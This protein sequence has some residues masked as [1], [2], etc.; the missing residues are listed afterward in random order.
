MWTF[1]ASSQGSN[2]ESGADVSKWHQ[3][4]FPAAGI[5]YN[6]IWGMAPFLQSFS[7][8]NTRH[9]T[10]TQTLTGFSLSHDEALFMT[11]SSHLDLM[12]LSDPPNHKHF[13]VQK[14]LYLP[15]KPLFVPLIPVKLK[16]M[17]TTK[18]VCMYFPE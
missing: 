15:K 3:M 2:S 4:T 17:L 5:R 13:E 8:P 11:L 9:V 12:T 6:N 14:F 16:H 7:S 18:H 10:Q 1:F